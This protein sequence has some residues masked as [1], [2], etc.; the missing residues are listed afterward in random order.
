[1][2][3]VNRFSKNKH[4]QNIYKKDQKAEVELDPLTPEKSFIGDDIEVGVK[5]KNVTDSDKNMRVR[6]TL[7]STF[8]TG[9]VGKKVQGEKSEHLIK[10]GEGNYFI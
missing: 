4:K 9:V 10:A 6:L 7:A 1:M 2:K 8:Y 5:V 3:F